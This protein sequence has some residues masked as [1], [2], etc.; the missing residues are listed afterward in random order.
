MSFGWAFLWIWWSENI[1]FLNR[2]ANGEREPER[3][4]SEKKSNNQNA[5]YVFQPLEVCAWW[6]KMLKILFL[7]CS[8]VIFFRV[9]R[10][11][12]RWVDSFGWKNLKFSNFYSRIMTTGFNQ[13]FYHRETIWYKSEIESDAQWGL[14]AVSSHSYNACTMNALAIDL[15]VTHSNFSHHTT[16]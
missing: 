2:L 9:E 10:D 11:M 5:N 6:W 14:P 12:R 13:T 7:L 3:D 16:S 8:V 4:E 1:P 15:L